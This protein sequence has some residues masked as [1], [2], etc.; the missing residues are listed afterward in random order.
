VAAYYNEFDPGA[1]AWLR[2]LIREG[3]IAD[4]E[5]DERSIVDVRPRDLAGFT[6]CHFFAGIGGWSYA[7]RLAGWADEEPVWT[8]SCP[9]QP[10]S[11]AGKGAGFADERHLWPAWHWLIAQCRPVVIFGEQVASP[12]GLAWFDLVSTDMEGLDYA[13]WP[14]DLPAAGINAPHIRQR[15]WWMADAGRE[16]CDRERLRLQPGRPRQASVKAGR[17]REVASWPTPCQQDGPNGGP[18]QGIDR[19]P[20]AAGLA[21]WATPLATDCEAAGGPNNPSLTNQATGRYA[22]GSRAA[23][24]AGGQLHPA[25]SR[26]LMGYPPAWDACAATAMPSSRKSRRRSSKPTRPAA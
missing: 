3:L 21:A 23:T 9:C 20:G 22:S 26:W 24:V 7:L 1:A 15:L 13:C 25:L 17:C 2:E 8:G 4:G 10:F 16:R 5:V 19:L 18:S 12:A 14:I 6:Q 11:A